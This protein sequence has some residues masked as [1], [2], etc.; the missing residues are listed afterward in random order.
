MTMFDRT[1]ILPSDV[2]DSVRRAVPGIYPGNAY[3]FA[4]MI[5]ALDLDLWIYIDSNSRK[6]Q[7]GNALDTR[8]TRERL[9]EYG[10]QIGLSDAQIAS[11]LAD[12]F[13]GIA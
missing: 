1:Y 2:Q 13:L 8:A 11:I 12:T 6:E 4:L 7:I 9:V 5:C 10:H 3:D